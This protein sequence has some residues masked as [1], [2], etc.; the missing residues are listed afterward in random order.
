MHRI[1][2]WMRNDLRLHDNPVLEWAAKH[3]SNKFHTEVLPV[4]CFDPRFYERYQPHYEM[5]KCGLL[6]TRFNIE[7][8]NHF[9]NSLQ[10]IGSDLYLAHEK[11]EDFIA[12][13]VEADSPKIKT[14]IVY[15]QEITS[16]EL[17]VED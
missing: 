10:A 6:R 11:P 7:T 16:E 8:A 13:L 5:K 17:R 15:Q 2:L 1:I 12:K 14:T 3:K 9:R 4:Y